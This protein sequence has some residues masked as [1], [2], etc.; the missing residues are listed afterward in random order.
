[1][2]FFAPLVMKAL[3]L[4]WWSVIW[5]VN[6]FF[7]V[8]TVIFAHLS[9]SSTSLRH[10]LVQYLAQFTL[11]EERNLATYWE[12]W[13][14]LLV[15]ILAF[16]RFLHTDKTAS[17]EKQ[18]WLGFSV[19]AAGLSLD[20]LGSI[21]EQVPFLFE[22]W[23]LS[24]S[25]KSKIPLAVPALVILSFT[26]QRMWGLVNRRH[27]WLTLSAFVL[28]GSVA[29]QE[30]LEHTVSWPWWAEGIRVGVEEGTE[31]LGVFLLLSVC[32]SASH[33]PGKVKSIVD[34]A[35]RTETLVQLKPAVAVV[36]L[37]SFIPLG[38]FTVFMITDAHH[39]GTPATWLP[40]M[41]LNLAW[42]AAWAHSQ[43]S[44][45]YGKRFLFISLLAFFFALDQIIVFERVIDRHLSHGMLG[46]LMFPCMA[47][48]CMA[49]PTL[50]TRSN[51]VLLGVLLPLSLLLIIPASELLPWFVFPLQSLAV[52][53]VLVSGLAGAVCFGT[54]RRGQYAMTTALRDEMPEQI[55][56]SGHV[57]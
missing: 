1:M 54:L 8:M 3:S 41:L 50:R 53:S 17:Y 45:R 39:R 55:V 14:L 6:V 34:L 44:G 18:A 51:M 7:L 32:M 57:R 20:E 12:G 31:L 30:H 49:I 29:F 38:L 4:K 2:K 25:V 43:L 35:P 27:F 10:G 24:G 28:F 56:K 13:C 26:L 46:T 9:G 37:S 19:L 23:G 42:M 15:S 48:A 52:V 11:A 33:A 22:P 21:H 16:E 36:T 47:A 40:F 5:G